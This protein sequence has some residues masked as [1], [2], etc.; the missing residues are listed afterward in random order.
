MMRRSTN[1]FLMVLLGVMVLPHLAQGQITDI[2]EV[3]EVRMHTAKWGMYTLGGWALANMAVSGVGMARSTGQRKAF[4]QM[5]VFWNVVNLGIAAGSYYGMA[6]DDPSGW[7][8]WESLDHQMLLEKAFLFNAALDL[9]YLAGGMYLRERAKNDPNRAERW[10]GWGN[11]VLLQGG[12][13]FAFDLSMYFI[14]HPGLQELQPFLTQVAISP[15][16][17]SLAIPLGR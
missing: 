12:F 1:L 8:A 14:I 6:A 5:N 13:L 7:T 16:G 15:T 10:R 2:Q 4:H 17:F 11:S 9:A 3:N